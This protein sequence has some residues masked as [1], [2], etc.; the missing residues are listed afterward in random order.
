P[1]AGDALERVR[2]AIVELDPRAGDQVRDRPGHEDLAGLR[3]RAHASPDVHGDS[4]DVAV[5][6]LQLTSVESG[7]D[8]YRQRPYGVAC[9]GGGADRPRRAVERGEEPVAH[10]LHLAPAMAL[11][12]T[13]HELVVPLY[14]LTP[15]AVAQLSGP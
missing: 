12:L 13:A 4:A 9:G 14:E 1:L 10:R 2:S 7:A 5:H 11:D 15:A 3:E 8:L 6:H